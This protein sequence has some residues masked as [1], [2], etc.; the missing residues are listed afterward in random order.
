MKYKAIIF[1]MDGV[2]VDNYQAWLAFDRKFLAQYNIVPDDAYIAYCNGRSEEEVV[3]WVKEKFK[4]SDSVEKITESRQDYIKEIYQKFSVPQKNA[5]ELLKKI[6]AS[7]YKI[8]L[9]SGAKLWMIETILK[10]FNWGQYFEQVVS[11]DHVN[12]CGKPNPEIYLH[13][14]RLLGVKPEECIVFEDSENGVVSAKNAG[15]TCIGY[16]NIYINDNLSR[17]DFIVN[18]LM[19]KK[20]LEFLNI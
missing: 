19:D 4:I 18:D 5:E 6:K 17:A 9:A 16:K 7:D 3:R 8:A 14:A 1:D 12:Y 13:T 10:R 2:L 20:V 11:S 15:M